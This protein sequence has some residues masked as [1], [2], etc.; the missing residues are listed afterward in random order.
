MLMA[1][2]RDF[3]FDKIASSYDNRRGTKILNR[4]YRPLVEQVNVVPGAAL[5]DVGCGTGTILRYI[6]D[7][8]A[9]QG[10]GIDIEENMIAEAK[11]KCP[12]MN[13][14]VSSCDNTPFDNQQFDAITACLAYHHFSDKKGF[15][16]EAARILKPEGILYIADPRFPWLIR[17]TINGLVKLFHVVGFFGTPQEIF[18]NF[19]EYGFQLVGV[20]KDGFAQVVKLGLVRYC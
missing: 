7:K 2:K 12:D 11:K 5:L 17:K 16:K 14:Q 3:K 10:Y 6:S 9:I 8:T 19:R 18:E 20:H 15:A 1:E 13:I 4:F